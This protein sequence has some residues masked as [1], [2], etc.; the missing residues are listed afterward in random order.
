L[1]QCGRLDENVFPP[2]TGRKLKESAYDELQEYYQGEY[3]IT[4]LWVWGIPYGTPSY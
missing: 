2:L 3:E 1:V 4:P